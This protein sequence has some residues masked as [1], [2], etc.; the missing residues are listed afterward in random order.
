MLDGLR[1]KAKD[2]ESV[3]GKIK[4]Q[5]ERLDMQIPNTCMNCGKAIRG[6]NG[7]G[8]SDMERYQ[9]AISLLRKM[10]TA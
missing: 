1:W 2:T 5:R 3:C 9:C 6:K 10:M 4:P 7:E 8:H